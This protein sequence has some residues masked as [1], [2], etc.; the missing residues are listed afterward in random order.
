M[1]PIMQIAGK[2]SKRLADL[3]NDLLDIQK[4]EAGKMSFRF[5]AVHVR[6][7]VKEAIEANKGFS[8][9]LGIEL[10]AALPAY[11]MVIQG[12]EGRLMQVMANLLSNG[13]KFSKEHGRI[14]VSAERINKKVRISVRDYGIGVSESERELVFGKF[15][16]IDSSDQRKVGGTGLGMYITKQI[17]EQ[18]GGEIDFV[19]E[20][21][22]G[23]TFFVEFDEQ[24]PARGKAP[25][26]AHAEADMPSL[27]PYDEVI[28]A[29]E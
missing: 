29:A 14:E 21:G 13:L 17:V 7:L 9:Q 22:R 18:H 10:V 6:A 25:Q 27:A 23:T 19:S 1:V 5:G 15:T 2:N 3:I 20:V 26:Q 8:D 16:Q 12:D 28:R 11:D 4:I 24:I